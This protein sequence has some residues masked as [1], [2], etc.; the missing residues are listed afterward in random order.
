MV[1]SSVSLSSTSARATILDIS[2][3]S[4]FSV[5]KYVSKFGKEIFCPKTVIPSV[6]KKYETPAK[7]PITKRINNKIWKGFTVFKMKNIKS[8]FYFLCIE[9]VSLIIQHRKHNIFL[10]INQH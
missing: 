7:A 10:T 9:N 3:F 4:V 5:E 8:K 1:S 2:V 6:G